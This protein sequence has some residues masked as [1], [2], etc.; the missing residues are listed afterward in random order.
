MVCKA[1]AKKKGAA[2]AE[3]ISSVET[4]SVNLPVGATTGEEAIQPSASYMDAA[5][6]GIASVPIDQ[7]QFNAWQGCRSLVGYK[8][9]FSDF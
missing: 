5:L 4:V 3:D 2:A 6:A 8:D 9:M 1:A 7:E